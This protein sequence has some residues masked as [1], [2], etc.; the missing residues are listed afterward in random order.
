MEIKTVQ[1]KYFLHGVCRRGTLC[2]FSHNLNTKPDNICKFYKNG[3]CSYGKQ[4]RY[5]HVRPIRTI[6]PILALAQN[7]SNSS[8]LVKL[9][10][11]IDKSATSEVAKEKWALAPEFVPGQKWHQ[12]VENNEPS[13]SSP[14]QNISYSQMA[15]KN[16][17][18]DNQ[19]NNHNEVDIFE[20]GLSYEGREGDLLCPFAAVRECPDGEECQY[21]HGELCEL[22]GCYCLHPSNEMQQQEHK[23]QC[24]QR[25]EANMEYSFAVQRSEGISCSICL[26]VVT[27]KSDMA[28]RMFGILET[29]I[30]PFCLSCIR[31][32][33]SS[34]HADKTVVRSCPI[35]RQISWFVTPSLYWVD[36]EDEKEKVITKYKNYLNKKPCRNFDQGRG[37]CPFGTSCFY[38]HEYENGTLASSIPDLRFRKDAEGEF[39]V[40]KGSRL[41]EFIQDRDET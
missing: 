3:S 26:E 22:C 41:Y 23:K 13:E 1:C 12:P 37:T 29:C 39:T 9:N 33:R 27:E 24:L 35:C 38:K 20:Y 36:E 5:D 14:A 4:C 17:S 16:I 6:K 2:T 25:H 7:D 34:S 40:V 28:E 15:S 8:S 21:L 30:H 32:W 10:L 19:N 31:N 18:S 11:D